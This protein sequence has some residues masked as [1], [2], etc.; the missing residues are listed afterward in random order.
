MDRGDPVTGQADTWGW[1][2]SDPD[3]LSKANPTRWVEPGPREK[4]F[5]LTLK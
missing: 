1:A 2:H 4:T 3:Q 5:P